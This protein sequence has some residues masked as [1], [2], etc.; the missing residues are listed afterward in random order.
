MEA[1]E[2]R[3]IRARSTWM[4]VFEE[5]KSVSKTSRK[6]GVPRSTI[7]RWLKRYKASGAAG[8]QGY[9]R[10]PKK[11]AKQKITSEVEK[12]ILDIRKKHSWGPLR[13]YLHFKQIKGPAL[14]A[15][16]IWRVLKRNNVKNVKKYRRHK[17][18]KRYNR[19]IPG[20]RVQIDV[21][22]ITNGYFQYTAIDDCTRLK[23]ARLYP[24]KNAQFSIEFLYDLIDFFGKSVF[25]SSEYRQI[26]DL[27]FMPSHYKR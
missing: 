4:E 21:T 20:D 1:G 14:S 15:P 24:S 5:T 10:R 19:P 27:S 16:T 3:R 6:C 17:D 7:Y 8:L 11:F 25:Q 13:I 26:A 2:Q 9:S 22:K 23:Y 18:F 12:Q